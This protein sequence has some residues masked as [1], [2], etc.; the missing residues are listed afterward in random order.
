MQGD[1]RIVV[2]ATGSS[3]STV[4]QPY[5]LRRD[6]KDKFDKLAKFSIDLPTAEERGGA[7]ARQS[8]L[9]SADVRVVMLCASRPMQAWNRGAGLLTTRLAWHEGGRGFRYRTVYLVHINSAAPRPS[10]VMYLITREIS[11]RKSVIPLDMRAPF[12]IN[13]LD[14]LLVVHSLGSKVGCRIFS[15]TEQWACT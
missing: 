13:V 14:N 2:L 3:T 8:H 5:F 15:S 12:L 1:L 11:T 9:S 7:I 4:F 10:L 6:N